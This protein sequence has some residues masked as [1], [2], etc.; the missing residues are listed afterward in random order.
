M[1]SIIIMK[2]ENKMSQ[3][4]QNQNQPEISNYINSLTDQEKQ[5]LE[6]AKSHLGTSFNIMKSIGF[7]SWKANQ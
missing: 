3:D 5:T 2:S 1:N 4:N 6:I 7:L